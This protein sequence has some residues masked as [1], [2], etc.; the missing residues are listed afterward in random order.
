MT[1]TKSVTYLTDREWEPEEKL[2]LWVLRQAVLDLDKPAFSQ[3]ATRF[4]LTDA[5]LICQLL[6]LP[7]R[8]LFRNVTQ[9]KFGHVRYGPSTSL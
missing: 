6:G 5:E 2:F 8:R 4:L 9:N 3:E 1:D 7:Y